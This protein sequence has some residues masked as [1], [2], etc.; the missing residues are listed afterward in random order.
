MP[1]PEV[2]EQTQHQAS[3]SRHSQ[4][5]PTTATARLIEDLIHS[6]ETP[7]RTV[8]TE[9][10]SSS[11]T[12]LDS[13]SQP[14]ENAEER[15]E[16][17][18]R[19]A[20]SI[21]D[22]FNQS[23]ESLREE[24][25]ALQ[26]SEPEYQ[27]HTSSP[28]ARA[29]STSL[30]PSS[31]SSVRTGSSRVLEDPT[32][33]VP[34][35]PTPR[36]P[37]GSVPPV[38]PGG[39][40]SWVHT[41][42]EHQEGPRLATSQRTVESR[43]P[44]SSS[45]LR[46]EL[47]ANPIAERL[48]QLIAA[49]VPLPLTDSQTG[50]HMGERYKSVP[51]AG[52]PVSE[53][54]EEQEPPL[55]SAPPS[56]TD[57]EAQVLLLNPDHQ[58]F[59][60]DPEV[61]KYLPYAPSTTMYALS[62]SE[63]KEFE[64]LPAS[65]GLT[66]AVRKDEQ[67]NK[68]RKIY[69]QLGRVFYGI[70]MPTQAEN[71]YPSQSCEI[72]HSQS[73]PT[74]ATA[75]LIEDLIHSMETPGRT[76]GTE[77]FSSSTTPLDSPSQPSENAEER[78][79]ALRRFASSIQDIFNQSQESNAEERSE[80]LRRFASSIQDIFNQSQE[81]LREESL[82]LQGSEPEYQPHTS[83]PSARAPSTSLPPSSVS[84]VRT[85][86]SRI[87][88][89][90]TVRVPRPPTP[91]P[92]FGSVPPVSPGGTSSWVHTPKEHQEGPRL[93]TSQRTVESRTPLSSSPLRNEL[94]TNPIAER[95]SQL[96]A[97]PVP[98]PLTDSQTGRHMGERYKSVPQAGSPVSERAEEQEPPLISAPPS[99][100][101]STA[102]AMSSATRTTLAPAAQST[103]RTR[104][105]R[106]EPDR[107]SI[108][109]RD[110]PP[111]AD[112]I[113]RR[114]SLGERRRSPGRT[115]ATVTDS[116]ASAMS[117]ATRTTLAPAA[118]STPRTRTAREEPDRPSILFRDLP[119]HADFINRR[120]SLGERRRSP[121]RTAA[122]VNPSIRV[123]VVPEVPGRYRSP[124]QESRRSP[125]SEPVR[126]EIVREDANSSRRGNFLAPLR[127]H[128]AARPVPTAQP[129]NRS[130]YPTHIRSRMT[131]SRRFSELFQDDPPRDQLR[132]R[133][134]PIAE[135]SGGG[136]PPDDSDSRTTLSDGRRG[137]PGDGGDYGDSRTTL[138]DGRRG[139][140]GDG[141]D[142]GPPDGPGDNPDHHLA[143][144]A[145]RAR[146]FRPAPVHF[147][148]KLKPEIIPEW[149]G[150]TRRLS[151]WIISINNIAEYSSY[152]RVQLGQQVP[153]RFVGRA[154]RWFNALDKTYRRQI[155]A[156]WPS[157]RR[158]ITIHF[159]N[160]TFMER[161]KADA[162][163]ARFR[164]KNHPQ[165]SPEDY[166]IRKMEALTILS[167]WTDSEL[168]TEI[169]NSAPEHWTL[170]IDTSTV[171][172]WD[173]FLDK[174]AWHEEKLLN[175]EISG[176]SDIQ[177]QLNEMK[178]MLKRLDNTKHSG[179]A[180]ARSHQAASKPVGWH[181]NNPSPPYPKDDNTVSKDSESE[182]EEDESEQDF[183]KPL[184]SL[185]ALAGAYSPA[186][187][188]QGSEGKETGSAADSGSKT[189]ATEPTEIVFAGYALP[190]LPTR[191]GLSK[192]LKLA[193]I[194]TLNTKETEATEPT[195]IV[196]A[197]YALP[198][199]PTRK[200][201]SK[202]LKLA[203]ITT[204]NTKAG[205]EITLKR[206]MSRPPGTAFFG[207]KATII[208]GWIQ[209]LIGPK[210]RITFD[211]GSEIT[212][213]NE[214]LL[215][216][217]EP[218]PRVRIGQKLRL[219]QVTSNS[220]LSQYITVPLIFD[221]NE[222]LV[223]MTVEAY[224]VPD[225]NTPFILGT[226]FAA[227]YQ[228]SLVRDED[229]TR[230]IFG[231]TGRSIQVEESDSVP[232]IDRQGNSFLV[233][234]AQGHVQNGYKRSKARKQYKQRNKDRQ[235]PLN[236]VKVKVYQTVIIPAH[237]I[238]MVK[239]KTTWKEGQAEGFIDHAFNTHQSEEDIFAV[240]DSVIDRNN[241]RIQVSNS[242]RSVGYY[243]CPYY[244]DG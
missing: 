97:A 195:E 191:K 167:D 18:R 67:V 168:I 213:I 143:A 112:F 66:S 22:I 30:P 151:R 240:A 194:T 40:S 115:A 235:V 163:H 171:T 162:L 103:P 149:N 15:S 31:V 108:L 48:S 75:R 27:P 35:P 223:K 218:P 33:R 242:P 9:R 71:R 12:P 154:L 16:A 111:H 206:L 205:E 94:P 204:L 136:D 142:Y 236:A 145:A 59:S 90:P 241:P 37:F 104:T 120:T 153:L 10:F 210:K 179:R 237:T 221:T 123:A 80:A 7:G 53:R 105:A 129:I 114:T 45:P 69:R 188:W 228:L 165:E 220:S 155:T 160:R 224:I 41:P 183:R 116:T 243:T 211:S 77:R 86:S 152:T 68:F 85:G 110:L 176:S 212:L 244:Q 84:S 203:S 118:Q 62:N 17:L 13:P 78:S 148:T 126:A 193:S 135:G 65:A 106:E 234:A 57:H 177:R 1:P 42:K 88:E 186:N 157:L 227:Q 229:G 190:K 159:M 92:P 196:F 180:T 87:L 233:E 185:A 214:S 20:S 125:P 89:D 50:R 187:D 122:T 164:D 34:R 132:D 60:E 207:S 6:M 199:L 133:L 51:Q 3:S 96:I 147:D 74:T 55:I 19:F 23:Q 150:D 4:S 24:S 201:L 232:R 197:G 58:S 54:A 83:S 81:S 47:P 225:M 216:T 198:K 117:S 102:S 170:Y 14:S 139:Y 189:E 141:G 25:L 52:S 39:T 43:T 166:V 99:P 140:P 2:Q 109:F 107:P 130:D 200:G 101:D 208:K 124:S 175:S 178:S 222:G 82:V 173:D 127:P 44:L 209:S 73:P 98:L 100:T 181:K 138:S 93:A 239:V 95:L 182:T 76:V 226:D 144:H 26:G 32:V 230:I 202:Q 36:P 56:P 231:E 156:D 134:A 61:K 158:A 63:S 91:R 121:G 128:I 219:I 192:Q 161:N 215:K 137:Y 5:P 70:A 28:S 49:P 21:Q 8:G 11:T 131:S 146:P 72:R 119:P 172:T 46:N 38:S 217:L 169:M 184:Q 64:F 174:I 29:P 79:E 238:K 113:N